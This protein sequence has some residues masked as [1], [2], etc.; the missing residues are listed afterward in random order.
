M[1]VN[2]N[3]VLV[4]SKVVLIPYQSDHVPVSCCC[5]T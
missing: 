2:V 1:K 4:G 3:T 5:T